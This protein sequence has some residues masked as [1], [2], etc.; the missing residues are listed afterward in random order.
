METTLLLVS[1]AIEC[2]IVMFVAGRKIRK[3]IE[4]LEAEVRKLN[5][6][7]EELNENLFIQLGKRYRA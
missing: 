4:A 7:I 2:L 1:G 6:D 3:R 5:A